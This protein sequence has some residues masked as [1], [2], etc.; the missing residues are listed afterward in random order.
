MLVVVI[1][2]DRIINEVLADLNIKPIELVISE[3][4]LSWLGHIHRMGKERLT[5]D[6]AEAPLH[7]KNKIGRPQLKREDQMRQ[8]A[9]NRGIKWSEAKRIAQDRNFWRKMMRETIEVS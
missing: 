1:A 2:I 3:R 4:Q 9:E 5:N 7:P 6:V 8:E